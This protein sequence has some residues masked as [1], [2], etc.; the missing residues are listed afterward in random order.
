MGMDYV[1]LNGNSFHLN[2]TGHD[3]VGSLLDQL[4]ADMTEWSGSNDGDP[5]SERTCLEWA[6]LIRENLG[7]VQDLRIQ[8]TGY[9]DGYRTLAILAGED[10]LVVASQGYIGLLLSGPDLIGRSF[11]HE[12][13]PRTRDSLK[14]EPMDEENRKWLLEFVEFLE[15]CG[16]CE[17]W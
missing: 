6:K 1:G 10:P 7:S 15:S 2:W 13:K 5:I 4:G 11:G 14:V 17:Q 12:P 8:E 9:P 16:G 3:W